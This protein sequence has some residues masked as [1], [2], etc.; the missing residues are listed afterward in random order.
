MNGFASFYN[1]TDHTTYGLAHSYVFGIHLR[2]FLIN[3]G[4]KLL[5]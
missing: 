3:V 2:F 4:T 5:G 1:F